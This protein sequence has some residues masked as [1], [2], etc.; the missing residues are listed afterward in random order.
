MSEAGNE[1]YA[2]GIDN[3]VKVWD[4]R[5][6][7]V[8]YSMLGHT[9][10]ITSLELSPD[11]QT[12]LSHSMD[13]SVRTWDVRP[14]A[15]VDRHVKTYDGATSGLEKN[16]IRASWDPKGEKIAAGSEDRTVTIWDA[17]TGKLLYKLPGHKGSVNDVR[18]HPGSE[19]ISESLLSVSWDLQVGCSR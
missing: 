14:F 13:S 19:P 2:G 1:L 12:L 3:D 8:A 5:K 6:K 4:L 18:F 17:R 15:P 11:A 10:T 9:D 16:L 7:A